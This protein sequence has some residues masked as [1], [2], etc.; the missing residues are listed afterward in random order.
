[1]SRFSPPRLHLLIRTNEPTHEL[2]PPP[3]VLCSFHLHLYDQY[4]ET[5]VTHA[6]CIEGQDG[7]GRKLVMF[8]VSG[9]SETPPK[10]S[11]KGGSKKN[12]PTH[13][14][15][16]FKLTALPSMHFNVMPFMPSLK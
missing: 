1:L 7:H 9:L 2:P 12:T 10:R 6:A 3:L 11:S 4:F 5:K 16:W 14:A 15:K 13:E 8:I